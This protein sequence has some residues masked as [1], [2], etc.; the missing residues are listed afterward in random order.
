MK[1]IFNTCLAVIIIS[2][3]FLAACYD[4]D[5]NDDGSIYIKEVYADG[6]S[7]SATTK[8][9]L[10]LNKEMPG[11]EAEDIKINANFPVIKGSLVK[12]NNLIYELAITSGN[13]GTIRLGLDPY[14]GFTGWEAKSVNVFAI[15]RFDGNKELTIS[16]YVGSGGD[17]EIPSEI[18]GI[19]VT[20]IGNSVFNNKSLT[21]IIIPDTIRSIGNFAFSNNSLEEVY[22]PDSVTVIGISAFASNKLTE[23]IIPDNVTIIGSSAF[24][25]NGLK[26]IVIPDNVYNIGSFAF[27]NNKLKSVI[28][29]ERVLTIGE[30]AFANNKLTEI[31]IPDNVVTVGN[32]AFANNRLTSITISEKMTILASGIFAHNKLTEFVIPDNITIIRNQAFLNNKLESV[33][34]GSGVKTIEILAFWNNQLT[35][36]TIDE[37]VDAQNASFGDGFETAYNVTYE[38]AKGTY[39]RP[40]TETNLWEK[41]DD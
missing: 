26:D 33:T 18:M 38:K 12:T 13:S 24:A 35:S 36:I 14:R 31:V 2:V 16:N 40:D 9:T 6:S 37:K 17:I 10:I 15:L 34:I 27:D 3:L 4:P 7:I 41:E 28:I 32:A 5:N 29:S 30:Y 8:L 20:A 21:G 19:P 23:I 11:L 22:I 1:K 25:N 39:T